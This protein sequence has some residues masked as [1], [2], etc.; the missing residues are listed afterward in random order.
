MTSPGRKRHEAPGLRERK[1]AETRR[2]IQ[3]SALQM[4]L[5]KGYDATTVDQIAEAAGVSHMT[6]F[7]HFRTKE[8]VVESDDYDPLIAALIRARP[9]EEEPLTALHRAL[10]EGLAAVYNADRDVLLARTRLILTTPALRAHMADNQHATQRLFAEA[11]AA[12]GSTGVTFE[13][14]VHSA[15]A[16]AALTVALTSWVSSEG[17]EDLPQLVDRAFHALSADFPATALTPRGRPL[18]SPSA[19]PPGP[20]QEAS[21]CTND[22]PRS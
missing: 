14:Q 12:R 8:A 11:L 17:A 19:T 20:D 15:A 21:T 2:R 22:G 18:L 5:T 6:F 13:L 4:F 7:R 10:A 3:Q 1:K 16:L 9:P